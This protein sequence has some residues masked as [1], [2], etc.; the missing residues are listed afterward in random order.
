MKAEG[1]GVGRRP[2]GKGS[3]QAAGTARELPDYAHEMLADVLDIVW[4]G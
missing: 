2:A 4:L 3:P 1:S